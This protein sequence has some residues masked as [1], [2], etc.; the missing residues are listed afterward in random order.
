MSSADHKLDYPYSATSE[1]YIVH[2]YIQVHTNNIINLLSQAVSDA[3]RLQL[4]YTTAAD[5]QRLG[6][7]WG[8]PG[9]KTDLYFNLC[10]GRDGRTC[11]AMTNPHARKGI[12]K[13]C[14]PCSLLTAIPYPARLVA[15]VLKSDDN[16]T[17]RDMQ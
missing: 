14:F 10:A 7:I 11:L 6:N 15:G 4:V 9:Q 1:E 2:T 16:D 3:W 5:R 17:C 13:I 12:A 8:C